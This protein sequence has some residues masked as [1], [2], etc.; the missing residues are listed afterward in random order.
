M[1][2][3]ARPQSLNALRAELGRDADLIELHESTVWFPHPF[4]RLQELRRLAAEVPEGNFLRLSTSAF[5]ATR[6]RRL[7]NG[8]A[9]TP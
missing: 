8:R 6:A 5:R 4:Q 3:T 2:V 1:L 9:T 7:A